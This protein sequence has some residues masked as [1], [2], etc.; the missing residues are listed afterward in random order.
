MARR[1]SLRLIAVQLERALSTITRELARNDRRRRYWAHRTDQV[2]W[3][4]AR[5]RRHA[6]S[7][8]ISAPMNL[9]DI[10]HEWDVI[11]PIGVIDGWIDQLLAVEADR[12]E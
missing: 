5:P 3:R 4:R 9:L 6:I 8:G 12:P 11:P 10:T 7:P 1:E 2:A